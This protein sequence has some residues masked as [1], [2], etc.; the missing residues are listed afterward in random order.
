LNAITGQVTYRQHSKINLLHRLSNEW[1]L[2]KQLVLDF[3]NPFRDGSG[4]VE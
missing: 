2:L 4:F 3:F 1:Q